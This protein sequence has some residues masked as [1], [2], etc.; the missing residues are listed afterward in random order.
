MNEYKNLEE[1][2]RKNPSRESKIKPTWIG[3]FR[4]TPFSIDSEY[5]EIEK[6]VNGLSVEDVRKPLG[7]GA[8]G[9]KPGNS[10]LDKFIGIDK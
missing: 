2:H 6:Q 1:R 5:D 9:Y 3:Q 4:K 7:N 10:Y 8:A